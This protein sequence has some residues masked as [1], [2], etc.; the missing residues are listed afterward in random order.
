MT[1][2][3]KKQLPRLRR[4]FIQH[5]KSRLHGRAGRIGPDF[6][7]LQDVDLA[8]D[9]INGIKRQA[10]SGAVPEDPLQYGKTQIDRQI[11]YPKF[12]GFFKDLFV[13]TRWLFSKKNLNLSEDRHSSSDYTQNALSKLIEICDD[14]TKT[15]PPFPVPYCKKIILH[16]V[17]NSLSS[18]RA[19]RLAQ[20]ELRKLNDNKNQGQVIEILFPSTANVPKQA[21]NR[22]HILLAFFPFL[23]NA[24][25]S[26]PQPGSKQSAL[27][28]FNWLK[29]IYRQAF[30]HISKNMSHGTQVKY[31]AVF[32]LTL[33][34]AL[35]ERLRTALGDA[36][37]VK[38]ALSIVERCLP[39]TAKEKK[40]HLRTGWRATLQGH[41][42]A[43]TAL[44]ATQPSVSVAD[45][46][47]LLSDQ[48]GPQ[49]SLNRVTWDA[50][51]KR[52]KERA[53]LAY[54]NSTVWFVLFSHLLPDN[55]QTREAHPPPKNPRR[56]FE[57]LKQQTAPQAATAL[58][59]VSAKQGSKP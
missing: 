22:D 58:P 14:L 13:Y 49:H 17:L 16:D 8:E 19:R 59:K 47:D 11:C 33:R 57:K 51:K 35:L 45:L 6:S 18:E 40:M 29:K 12:A 53:R 37:E 7:S 28:A 44:V 9:A 50:W 48:A 38:V 3:L 5:A 1:S 27:Q 20:A 30:D 39:W 56:A 32:L 2:K 24:I 4:D 42:A 55:R 54:G 43:Y 46:C 41:W 34:I 15:L 10:N 31:Y 23:K 26:Q 36:F 25:T 52:A 21:T